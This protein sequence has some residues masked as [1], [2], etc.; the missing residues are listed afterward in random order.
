MGL[1][2]LLHHAPNTL[3]IPGTADAGH[4]EANIAV[5]AIRLDEPTLA[6]L[7]RIPSRS[8]DPPLG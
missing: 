5:G 7:D 4:L 6:A 3:L 2:W 8:A 1:A